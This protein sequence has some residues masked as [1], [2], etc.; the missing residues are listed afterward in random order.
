M[1]C[2]QKLKRGPGI[3]E[4]QSFSRILPEE[5]SWSLYYQLGWLALIR[6]IF[7]VSDSQLCRTQ[8]KRNWKRIYQIPCEIENDVNCAGLAE[9]MSGNG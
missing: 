8:F 9:V 3:R 2:R 7:T 6:E 4:N 5:Q 1:K